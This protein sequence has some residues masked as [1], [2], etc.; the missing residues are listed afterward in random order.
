MSRGMEIKSP[1]PI[2]VESKC[3]SL[4]KSRVPVPSVWKTNVPV[5][6]RAKRSPN[7]RA[8]RMS[9]TVGSKYATSKWVILLNVGRECP[10]LGV[11]KSVG[12][13][14]N[15]VWEEEALVCCL[16][17]ISWLWSDDDFVLGPSWCARL[18]YS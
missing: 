17:S 4:W 2:D 15:T 3:P 5:W 6:N 16:F 14:W 11:W 10:S 1:R 8:D 9:L 18:V 12:S 7:A 13:K